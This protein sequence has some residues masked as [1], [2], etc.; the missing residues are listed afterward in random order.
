MAL[1]SATALRSA[2][3]RR[4]SKAENMSYDEFDAARDQ[5]YEDTITGFSEE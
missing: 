3:K 4:C 2:A 1:P 5:A